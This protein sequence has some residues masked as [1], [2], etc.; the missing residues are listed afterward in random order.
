[1]LAVARPLF[2][3]DNIRIL[4]QMSRELLGNFELMVLL[5]LIGLG[6][7]AYGVPISHAIEESTGHEVL[8]GSV[9]AALDRLAEKGFVTSRVGEPTPERGGRAKRYF[10][11]TAKGLRQVRETRRALIKLW[12]RIPALQG[13]T[14]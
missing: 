3:P 14:P 9:Y 2:R 1:M 11:I 12:D 4:E 10:R 6:D 13:G 8:V 5:A 7:E